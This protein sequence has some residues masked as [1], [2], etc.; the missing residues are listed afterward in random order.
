Y[1]YDIH[2]ARVIEE[3]SSVKHDYEQEIYSTLNI[4]FSHHERFEI[5]ICKGDLSKIKSLSDRLR[6]I[7]ELKSLTVN[8]FQW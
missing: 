8:Y 5:N 1:I 2:E 4:H 7:K 3:L 6:E